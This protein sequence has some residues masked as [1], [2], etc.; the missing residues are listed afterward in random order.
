[1]SFC[2][3]VAGM[4]LALAL[5]EISFFLPAALHVLA[6]FFSVIRS[7]CSLADV[8]HYFYNSVDIAALTSC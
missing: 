5:P 3:L 4:R 8:M 7:L 6:V 2:R 1:M